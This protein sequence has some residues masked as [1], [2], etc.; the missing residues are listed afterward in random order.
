MAVG[1]VFYLSE[2]LRWQ[3]FAQR[4]GPAY[5]CRAQRTY[6]LW[7]RVALLSLQL[8]ISTLPIGVS[9]MDQVIQIWM[10]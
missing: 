4:T 9:L 1:L 7:A 6:K 8:I 5:L 10:D 3:R 2:L